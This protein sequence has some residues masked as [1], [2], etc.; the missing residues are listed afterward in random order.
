MLY[1]LLAVVLSASVGS[2]SAGQHQ[3]FREKYVTATRDADSHQTRIDTLSASAC[4]SVVC[5]NGGTC[6]AVSLTATNCSCAT[7]WY[8]T[9]C[10]VDPCASAPCLNGGSCTPTGEHTVNCTCASGY[11]GHYCGVADTVCEE[12]PCLNGGNYSCGSGGGR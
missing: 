7:G 8:G 12:N 6:N 10:D 5:A 4:D 1:F 2:W 3:L 11:S 9:L